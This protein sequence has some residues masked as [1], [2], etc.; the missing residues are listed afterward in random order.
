MLSRCSTW[1]CAVRLAAPAL[2]ASMAVCTKWFSCSR[3]LLH[4]RQQRVDLV[5]RAPAL[6]VVVVVERAQPHQR[7]AHEGAQR[8]VDRRV[9][10]DARRRGGG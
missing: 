6:A 8:L 5:Q 9:H 10:V 1:S 2:R 4:L 3:W 7:V